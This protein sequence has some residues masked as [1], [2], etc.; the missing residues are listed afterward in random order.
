MKVKSPSLLF[1]SAVKLMALN[2]ATVP[3][4]NRPTS[5]MRTP[6]CRTA[7]LV[8]L[9]LL[10]W[11]NQSPAQSS[12]QIGLPVI[13][14]HGFCDNADSFLQDEEAVKAT[15]QSHYSTQYPTAQAPNSDE[16]ITFYDGTTVW[17][18]LPTKDVQDPESPNPI[19]TVPSSTRFFVVALDDPSQ[20]TYELFDPSTV[21]DIPIYTKGN[22]L[23]RIIWKIKAITGA[24]R[25]IV[26]AHSM[27]GLDARSYIEGLASPTGD[28]SA[29]I[30]YFNDIAALIT[31]DTPHGGS[32]EAEL[33][34]LSGAC[35]V[36]SSTDKSE[37]VPG[38][39]VIQQMNYQVQ[40]SIPLPLPSA[41]TITSIASYWYAP[42]LF[43]RYD[44]GTD[45]VLSSLTQDLGTNL[46]DTATDSNST[47]V[48][49]NNTFTTDFPEYGNPANTCGT[50]TTPLHFLTCTG[51]ASQTLG[52]LE[53]AV[54]PLSIM[55]S[56][57]LQISSASPTVGSGKAVSFSETT[58][59]PVIWSILE[60][61]NGGSIDPSSGAYQ[62]PANHAPTTETFHVVAINSQNP[63]Q[64]AEAPINVTSSNA[65]T[66]SVIVVSPSAAQVPVGVSLTINATVQTSG[67]T[68]TGTVTFYD[69][70]KSL[71]T[72]I[73]N[74]AGVATYSTSS[75]ALGS[76]SITAQYSGDSNYSASTTSSTVTI[77]VVAVAP[78]LSVS[79]TS[80]TPGVTS[81]VKTDT[82]FTPYGL[83]TH[84]AIFPD[85]SVSVLQTNADGNGNYSYS[86]T[87]SMV[88]PYSQTDTDGTTG[89]TTKA[90]TWTVSPVVTND[91]SLTVSPSSQTVLQ[92]GS[93]SYNI[94]TT[95][96]SGTAQTVSFGASN[97][98]SGLSATFSPTSVT[99]G[100]QSTLTITASANVPVGKYTLV[101]AGAS[102]YT[103]HT[104]QISVTVAQTQTGPVMTVTPGIVR[105]NDQSVGTISSPQTVVLRNSGTGQLIITG[106]GLAS[107]N[108]DYALNLSGFSSPL[109]LNQGVTY[110]LPVYFEP[111]S[112][113]TRPGQIVIYDNAPGSP[114]VVSLTGNG[115]AAQPST[116]TINVIANLNGVT[117]PAL[118]YYQYSLAG[119][120]AVT[121]YDNNSF[122]VTAG[123]YS[124]TFGNNPSYFTLASVTPSP[125]QSVAAGGTTTFTLNFTAPNDFYGPTFMQ[126]P[127][128]GFTP[129]II[130]AGSTATYYVDVSMPTGN[131]SSPITLSVLGAPTSSTPTF[132]PQPMYS[133][134]GGTLTIGT[135]AG[136]TQPGVYALTV[137]GTN[138]N[139]VTHVGNT[140]SLAVTALPAT[141]TQLVSQ[142]SSGIQANSGGFVTTSSI[143]GDGRFVAFSS[144]S[145]NLVS[146]ATSGHQEV[147]VRDIQSATTSLV[148]VSTSGVPADSDS[149]GGSMSANGQ[150]V[151]F[152]S[153]A[154]NLYPGS[155]LNAASGVYVRELAQGVTEREDVAADGTPANGSSYFGAI[156]GDG[157]YVAF[158]STATNLV[159]GVSGTQLYLRDRK[160]SQTILIS[161]SSDGSPANGNISSESISADGRYIAFVSSATNLVSQ[162]TNGV[163]QAFVR[164]VASGTTDLVSVSSKGVPA[165]T[166]VFDDSGS[167]P[168]AISADGRYVA[169]SSY[170]TNLVSQ[171]TDGTTLHNFV[172]DRQSQQ[173]ALAD[174][175]SVGT[176]LSGTG[177]LHPA[178][179]L[180]GR[181][182]AF[183]GFG[184]VLVRDTVG[185]Q[186]AV[187]SLASNGQA[188]NNS[189]WGWN[190]G[191]GGS[192][193]SFASTATNLI[194]NDLNGAMDSFVASNPFV[195][196]V[197]LNSLGLG[198]F[199]VLG[200]SN[201]TGTVTLSG[202]APAGGA[203]VSVWSNNDAA[204]PPAVV[205]VPTGATSASFGFSTSLVPSESV[206]TILAA[207]NGGSSV[208]VLTLEPAPE[209][210]VSPSTW[211]F[212]YQAVGTTSAIESFVL[213]N[214]GTASLTINSVQLATGQVFKISANSCGSSIA[215]GGSCSVS[216]A[217]GPSASGS[218]SDAVQISYGSPA[219]T[220]SISLT[221]NGATPVAALTPAPLS[222]G[223]Q[224]MPGSST[225]VATLTNSGDASLSSISASIS[226]T[227]AGDFLISSDGCS[228]VVLP[229]NSNCLVT[230]FFSPKAKGSR[231]ATLSIADSASGS[232]QTI[233]LMGTGVQSTPTL[234][235]S[236]SAASILYGTS[237]GTGL[238]DATAN[239]N[240]NSIGGAFAYTATL[241]G[242]APQSVSQTTVLAAGSYTLTA[243]FTPTDTTDYTGAT[244]TVSLT[245][246]QATQTI[247]FANPG[248]QTVGTPL[249]L[250]ATATSGLAVTFSS[251]TTSIC[252]VSGTTATFIASGTCTIDANQAGNSTYAAATM[253]PQS[254]TVNP[255]PTF[256]GSGGGGTISI[257]PGAT[258]GNTVT[259]SVAPSNGFNGTVNL[260]C[261]ISPT[262]ASD[263][264]TC[265]L[266]PSSVTIS[267]STTQT[268]TLTI[269][270][271]T[272]TSS[273]NREMRLFWPTTGCTALAAIL[274]I[275]IPRRRRSW[276]TMLGLLILFVSVGAVGCGGGG[277]SG[278]GGGG[279]GGNAGTTPGTYTVTV[280]GTSG[281]LTITLGTVTLVVK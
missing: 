269:N 102:S 279:G 238:L 242:G 175:D 129:Q 117:L 150:Y 156:S 196:N 217:F 209:L 255:A 280:T 140:S 254:F 95:T 81:F 149:Y 201:V 67:G 37:M 42:G 170:A 186:T 113:G 216:V 99:T 7:F 245:V 80:G 66:A 185:S 19:V 56:G 14:V 112:A 151:V 268:S 83:I 187:V 54:F 28:T 220:F 128:G 258:T 8:L 90:A 3:V 277:N 188:G 92:S 193:V 167:A 180:D 78:Q 155:V 98:P 91:F 5:R 65:K 101:V 1:N 198:S 272:A 230:V 172:Y 213:T 160:T 200:G 51:S 16:Y 76:H 162:N 9:A 278:G 26:V 86:R 142:S 63:A 100:S 169:F 93:V 221:G 6:K 204:Q 212:G 118:Y 218:A 206:M 135:T 256:T 161:V 249:T 69:G 108:T 147:Y 21:A 163:A 64:Y 73:L 178:V 219:T 274:F 119:P 232:P 139:G 271:T 226:G 116:G 34:V 35:A 38:G 205:T 127:G 62:A 148:S 248:T 182:V 267:G 43:E 203:I 111:A 159:S 233:S 137:S 32:L 243:T 115:L 252:T 261:S 58:G 59:A 20:H 190:I 191:L 228:G 262:A 33:S 74:N 138:S 125:S 250:S 94:V 10:A 141:P 40:G 110:S 79:P 225:E 157:R 239:L 45:D 123:T 240:G 11:V 246:N 82:G 104:Y 30:S 122:S 153:F 215:A 88:G 237:L 49:I 229:A 208:A 194:A 177:F 107:G 97:L 176:P 236:P 71:S 48:S 84:T 126:P 146:G 273:A 166:Y 276:L 46:A 109:I 260:S 106:I 174:V 158:I 120:T 132:N 244:T 224:S 47:L 164:D 61:A 77:T 72:A 168:P 263:P 25:V 199:S 251:T 124:I 13:F 130:P 96:T 50:P 68:P 12:S 266:S 181:F 17:F 114:Q 87:Y 227:N 223:N 145:T 23:A 265:G 121:G 192:R 144:S 184:Q 259:I 195:G 179:S 57:Q 18:Q 152:Y 105:F 136:A 44:E 189:T 75:L 89:Q 133:G 29:A 39:T 281:S 253:V 31:L 131:A 52:Y 27:G 183:Y 231:V 171:P 4:N 234:L 275:W 22:E 143:S 264:A 154:D 2:A 270:T 60:G 197:S 207:Y 36:N 53:G 165:N 211:D 214:S 41:L 247:T 15:L 55:T 202:A 70:T 134:F 222:F 241:N 24:P 85:N 210:A 257:E 103:T 173:I 235:W